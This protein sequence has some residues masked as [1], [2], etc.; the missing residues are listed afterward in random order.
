MEFLFTIS[1][2][3][4]NILY[5]FWNVFL[6]LVPCFTVY[7]LAKAID[8]SSWRQIKWKGRV[9]FIALFLFWLFFLP[10]TAY[11]FT[12]VRHLVNYCTDFDRFHVCAERAWVPL[13]FFTFALIG[14][15]TFYYALNKM[16]RVFKTL[17]GGMTAK[18]FPILIVPL[19]SIGMMFGLFERLNTWDILTKPWF[20]LEV[21]G[22][23]FMTS[24]RLT[25]FLIF[26]VLLYFI[27]YGTDF[28][29]TKTK[30]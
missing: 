27:Y 8:L 26:T 3:D 11:L 23:Y 14:V 16:T 4:Y 15:P 7:Y 1:I 10:N 2:S 29:I 18:V 5:L 28:L 30:K 20:I 22:S 13:F 24:V 9:G 6:A 21:T 25:D 17:F 12:M 19:T